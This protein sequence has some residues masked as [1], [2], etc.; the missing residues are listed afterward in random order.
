MSPAKLNSIYNSS[1]TPRN[2]FKPPL[3]NNQFTSPSVQMHFSEHS[4][5]INVTR[6]AENANDGLEIYG[7]YFLNK[8]LLN[9]ENAENMYSLVNK[10]FSL[11]VSARKVENELY[12]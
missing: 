2:S 11:P 12:Q 1:L 9:T 10:N 5:Y 4:P 6:H 8:S 3:I 7:S